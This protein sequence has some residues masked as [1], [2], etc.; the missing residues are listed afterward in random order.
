MRELS[1]DNRSHLRDLLSWTQPIKPRH[2]RG[3]QAC[4]DGGRRRWNSSSRSLRSFLATRF[5][6]RLGHFFDEQ[7]NAVS[8]FDDVLPNARRQRLVAANTADHNGDVALSEPVEY[9]RGNVWPSDP[10]R[11]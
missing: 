2:Q 8:A 1:P 9:Q 5:Q 7:R 3:M 6:H 10:G 11:L 4:G